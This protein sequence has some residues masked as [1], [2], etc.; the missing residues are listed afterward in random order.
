MN[1]INWPNR[2]I[3]NLLPS[4]GM[5]DYQYGC[6]NSVYETPEGFRLRKTSRRWQA[7]YRNYT[8]KY[9][10]TYQEAIETLELMMKDSI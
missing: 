5:S 1:E 4:R 8:T 9:R 2:E 7:Q 10:S 3:A 6:G